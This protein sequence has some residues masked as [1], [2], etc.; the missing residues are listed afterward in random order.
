MQDLKLKKVFLWSLALSLT[1]WVLGYA[2]S[3][4]KP[5]FLI[6]K[7][8]WYQVLWLPIHILCAYLVFHV[9]KTAMHDC[10]RDAPTPSVK[11]IYFNYMLKKS[12]IATVIVAPFLISDGIEGYE[13]VITDYSKLGA[14]GWLMLGIWAIEWVATGFLWIHV[15][16]TLKLTVDF[17]SQDY[18]TENLNTILLS[19]KNSPLLLAGVEN[20]I[21]VLIYGLASFGYIHIVGGEAS[22]YVAL[23]VSAIFVLLAFIGGLLVLKLR[24]EKVLDIECE[25]RSIANEIQFASLSECDQQSA[26][27]VGDAQ[28]LAAT[29]SIILE[30]PA[31]ISKRGFSRLRLI[32]A[33]LLISNNLKLSKQQLA[34][35]LFKYNEYEIRLS[36]IGMTELRAVLIRLAAPASGILA[37]LGIFSAN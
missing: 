6:S 5:A 23:G 2:L 31:G 34:L 21:V 17:Y 4:D 20:S 16:L 32:K 1:F 37:K 7:S 25:K 9:Y 22:D 33:S 10:H 24:I 8:W 18:I 29:S 36:T 11:K 26:S 30:K 28:D 19:N 13:M 15:L 12:I 35:E 3:P 27:S 14:S